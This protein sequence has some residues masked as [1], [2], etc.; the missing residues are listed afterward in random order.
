MVFRPEIGERFDTTVHCGT[1]HPYRRGGERNPNFDGYSGLLLDFKEAKVRAL[2]Y[3]RDFLGKYI[4]VDV[5]IAVVPSHDPAK[6]TSGL[7]ALA[8]KL[9]AGDRIDATSCLVRTKNVDKLAL[10]GGPKHWWSTLALHRGHARQDVHQ[11]RRA[12]GV[13]PTEQSRRQRP[14][15]QDRP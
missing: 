1:Y 2:E 14:A 5:P 9:A 12:Q 10:G 13:R 3:F 15:R 7:R 4:E 11:G 8:E 6:T